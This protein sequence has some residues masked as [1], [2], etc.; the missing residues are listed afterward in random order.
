M[1]TVDEDHPKMDINTKVF[2]ANPNTTNGK[3]PIA[4]RDYFECTSSIQ[5]TGS[6]Y[7]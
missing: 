5:E 2:H 7:R 1:S 6:F 4:T 3:Q